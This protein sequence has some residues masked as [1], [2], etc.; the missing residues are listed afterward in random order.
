MANSNVELEWIR[1]PPP[2]G[3]L[4]SRIA[5]VIYNSDEK[6]IFGRT[7]KRW[8]IAVTF[9]L[10]FYAVLA[11]LFALC[12]GGLFLSLDPSKPTYT[13]HSSLI[14]A[15]PG[16]TFRP[17]PE[18]NA[19]VSYTADQAYSIEV[20]TRQLDEILKTYAHEI[21]RTTITE[22]TNEDAYGFPHTPCFYIKLNKIFDWE[23]EYYDDPANLPADM[24]E[25]LQDY[26]QNSD[27]TKLKQVWVS[28]MEEGSNANSTRIEYPWGRGLLGRFPFQ[29][30][31][32]HPSPVLAVKFI[33]P[34]NTLFTVR[35]R[36]WAK[37]I[38]HNKSLKEP[39]GYT[40]L[41]IYV[42]STELITESPA[43]NTT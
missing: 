34:V 28:C 18:N 37:N 14:G 29:N 20:Y 9:Y 1:A 7:P 39:S 6:S 12:M 27:V 10:V 15:N 3:P 17:R 25:D 42:D 19:V 5:K 21:W 2:S 35:C 4:W 38:I 36:V 26:I 41:H 31:E 24:P 32:D 40:R 11:A 16:V 30:K 43:S 22:C 33:P 23:P 8:G 13:L